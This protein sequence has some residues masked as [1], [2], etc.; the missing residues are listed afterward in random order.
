[1]KIKDLLAQADE[2][3]AKAADLRAE[4]NVLAE[5]DEPSAE[6][7]QSFTA[8]TDQASALEAEADGLRDRAEKM[9]A[10]QAAIAVS[11]RSPRRDDVSPS[12]EGRARAGFEDD[13]RAGFAHLGEFASTVYRAGPH[14]VSSDE[15]MR[16]LA[17]ASGMSQG[18]N[19]DGGFLVPPAFATTI[20]DGLNSAPDNLLGRTD[21][22]TVE[23]ESLTIP[24]N[25]ETSRA[26]GSR[27]GGIRSYWLAEASQITSSKPTF[28]QMKLEP[29]ELAVLCYVTDK[30]LRNAPQALEQYLTRAATDEINF[31]VGDAIIN[32]DGAGKPAG[33][34]TAGCLVS[35][36][37]ETGQAADTV[38]KEN[39]DKIFA[40]CHARS[41]PNAAWLI[42]QDIYPQLLDL[43][44][45]IGT[46]GVPV[47]M[48]PGGMSGSPYGMLY[49]RPIVVTEYNATLGDL[50]DII[51]A[52]LG[53]YATG[54]QGG[55]RQAMSMHLRFDYAETAFRFMFAVDGQPWLASAITPYKGS[56]NT[57]SPFV[58]LAARA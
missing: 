18:V 26:T 8:K 39:I 29:H 27:Y 51:L 38:V 47:F 40:R 25:A 5:K 52:D 55:V 14:E 15:R 33:I 56:S 58:A 19:A 36:A 7:E 41:L 10:N 9:R 37:K 42:T 16:F 31:A 22:Y 53:A 20:W 30:L 32:G 28:R 48:P 1:M 34:L 35:V 17:A 44:H 21:Q 4:A 11:R 50:G 6:D 3:C 24:A 54:L 43:K 46:G 12:I 49:N 57:V 13:P 2:L 23:G 45:T